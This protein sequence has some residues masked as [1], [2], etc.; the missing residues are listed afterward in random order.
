MHRTLAWA[1]RV[2]A[3]A[4]EMEGKRADERTQR[5]NPIIQVHDQPIP[6]SQMFE[7]MCSG[8]PPPSPPARTQRDNARMAR[9]RPRMTTEEIQKML[10]ERD[11]ASASSSDVDEV[12]LRRQR[13]ERGKRQGRS[14][15][16][17]FEDED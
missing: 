6:K 13:E 14:S 8:R 12:R 1:M 16:H 15:R 4:L 17:R 10:D 3:A 5:G 11:A 9:K 2:A 7:P